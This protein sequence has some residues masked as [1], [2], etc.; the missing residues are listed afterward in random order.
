MRLRPSTPP[1]MALSGSP[2][3]AARKHLRVLL[4]FTCDALR[5]PDELAE[6]IGAGEAHV[7]VPHGRGKVR[8]VE[9]G[10]DGDG[11]FLGRG[12]PEFAASCGVGPGWLLVLRHHGGGVLTAKIFDDSS[13][14]RMR[15][16][17]PSDAMS[18]KKPCR[19]PQFIIVL[20]PGSMGKIV[21]PTRFVQHYIPKEHLDDQAAIVFRHPGRKFQI[22]LEVNQSDVLLAGGWTHF[23][24]FHCITEA[25]Y[26]ILR[27]E[28]NMV[29]TVKVFGVNGCPNE[30]THK[31]IRMQENLEKQLEAPCA[32]VQKSMNVWPSNDGQ[33][34]PKG[35][36]MTSLNKASLLLRG[37]VYKIGP[38]AWIKKVITI[39]ILKCHLNLATAFCDAIGLQNPSTIILKTSMN[40]TKGWS[41][42]GARI[43]NIGGY[44]IR[45]GWK[46][47]CRGNNLEEGDI[48]TFNV[49]E[50]TLW[51]VVITRYKETTNPFYYKLPFAFNR[52]HYNKNNRSN[53]QEKKVRIGSVNFLNKASSTRCVFEIGP[54]A[55]IKKEMNASTIQNQLSLPLSFCEALGL[56]EPCMISLKTSMSSTMSWQAL[57]VP[58]ENCG[59]LRGSGWKSFCL[60]N[61]VKEGDIC[62]FNVVEITLWHV[63]IVHRQ[64]R[65]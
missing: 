1:A 14:L 12:W 18:N 24:A 25:D 9:V 64:A 13:C 35:L 54:P 37:Y 42:Q 8:R 46:R 4:P 33:K 52:K 36:S 21:L 40:S 51:H 38:P 48:C 5:T 59:H 53:I 39:S 16:P 27:Y 55:W 58:Y 56:R 26:L 31:D 57:I 2:G 61:G 15:A 22:K 30:S 43:K 20:P 47:F 23:L 63:I 11:A 17:E 29:F 19:K 3:A 34:K 49:I 32:S 50:T 10:R 60:E 28:G 62:T 44:T 6:E 7:V 65:I 45:R 41:V